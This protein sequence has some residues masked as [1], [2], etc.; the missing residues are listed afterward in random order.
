MW[1]KASDAQHLCRRL[2]A[3]AAVMM[4][5]LQRASERGR[6][7]PA[8]LVLRA[9]FIFCAMAGSSVCLP[10]GDQSS[11]GVSPLYGFDGAAVSGV[12]AGHGLFQGN[13]IHSYLSVV[14]YIIPYFS[15]ATFPPLAYHKGNFYA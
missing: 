9:A 12:G 4:P 5:Q 3:R 14:I 7:V 11:F 6:P 15:R 1:S 8:P 13:Y 10:I 2:S